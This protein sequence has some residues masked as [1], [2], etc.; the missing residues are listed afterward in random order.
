M[1]YSTSVMA[2]LLGLGMYGLAPVVTNFE[3]LGA[4]PAL[5]DD[6]GGDHD[7]GDND[8]GGPDGG[9]D[10]NDDG[11]DNDVDDGDDNDVDE[12]DDSNIDDGDVS[13]DAA[14]ASG[15]C[16]TLSCLFTKKH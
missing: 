1:R 5:A 4:T 12:G 3:L 9:D 2:L 6:G 11:D 16:A 13:G 15:S 7:G 14:S 10:N 8:G